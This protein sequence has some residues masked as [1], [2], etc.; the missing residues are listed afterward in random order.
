MIRG[1]A[2]EV[3]SLITW[4]A[5]FWVGLS[6]SQELSIYFRS[7]IANASLRSAVS[8]ASLFLLTLIVGRLLRV[9]LR[10][11]VRSGGLS[12]S[13]R[14]AGLLVGTGRGA[15]LVAIIVLLAGLSSLP[16]DSRWRESNLV[17][18]FQSVALWLKR[19]VPTGV[20]G[21]IDYRH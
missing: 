15:L 1:F 9:I 16:R 5:A 19:Q 14:F 3:I 17:S 20:A 18:P 11:L 8:F 2:A 21:K 13:N 12:G 10:Q 4:T 7:M 6:F